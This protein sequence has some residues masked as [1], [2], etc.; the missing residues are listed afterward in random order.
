L[1]IPSI[2]IQAVDVDRIIDLRHRILRPGLP[3]ESA[4]FTGDNAPGALHLAALENAEIIG[5]ATLHL[6]TYNDQCAF[7][8]RGM[9]VAESHQRS[10]IGGLLLAE[11]DRRAIAAK[12]NLI[13]A[14]CRT[15]AVGFYQRH[16]WQI[17]SEEFI[18]ET[19]GPH[20]KMVHRLK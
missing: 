12:I 4:L 3:R 16:N 2:Q 18:I 6:S 5:C 19:A 14:N 8:L 15:A 10:G 7:Q 9:A 11:A 13:W 1:P 20:F 17:V